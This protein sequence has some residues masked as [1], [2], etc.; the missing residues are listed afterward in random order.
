MRGETGPLYRAY[1]LRCWQGGESGCDA[2]RPW[3]FSVEEIWPERRKRG[4]G[5]L[6][7]L[8]AFLRDE[9]ARSSD[10]LEDE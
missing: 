1:L 7:A 2:E 4:L 8:F 9:L 10:E 3:R 6:E 5:N